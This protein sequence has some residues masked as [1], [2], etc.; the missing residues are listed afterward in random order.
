[1]KTKLTLLAALC[2]LCCLTSSAATS[3]EAAIQAAMQVI[4]ATIK[5][6]HYDLARADLDA[7]GID[8]V[9]ALMNGKSGYCGSGGCTLFV[10][11]AGANGL[12]KVGAVKIVSR[13]IY[14]RKNTHHGFRD[15]LVSVRGGGATPGLAALEF[16][17]SSYPVSPGETKVGKQDDDAVLFADDAAGFEATRELQGITFKV[18]SAANQVT[19]T[20][21]G[22]EIDNSPVSAELKGIVKNV[23]VGDINADGSPEI[24]VFTAETSGGQRAGL[25]AYSTNKKKS[26]S[27]IY[28]SP[29]EDDAKNVKGYRGHDDMAVVEGIIARRFPIFPD[30]A[31]KAEPTGKTRQL[32]YK[33]KAGE[34]GWVLKLDKVV[35]Y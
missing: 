9:L 14:L 15:L 20:P 24:Y 31:A 5:P 17:G 3:D 26:L 29:L 30:D 8:D 16:D 13:P 1:M 6:N 4:D 21:S 2:G 34:A 32:Q 19:I 10:F 22:L 28:L 23:E 33:L 27:A 11:K 7:D 12:S 35:E 25:I 18:T